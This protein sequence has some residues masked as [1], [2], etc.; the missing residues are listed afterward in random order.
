MA[1]VKR[2]LSIKNNNNKFKRSIFITTRKTLKDDIYKRFNDLGLKNYDDL[3]ESYNNRR[4]K[5]IRKTI[6][7]YV[8]RT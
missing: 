2:N 3:N 8:S 6:K 1:R 7:S 4:R 5:T